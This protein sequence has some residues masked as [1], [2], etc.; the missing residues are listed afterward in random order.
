MNIRF[1]GTGASGGVPVIGCTCNVCTS[2]NIK[3]HRTRPSILISEPLENQNIN[4]LVDIAPEFREQILK[5][6][7]AEHIDALIITHAHNDHIAGLDDI[8][9]INRV[10]KKTIETFADSITVKGVQNRWNYLFEGDKNYVG[11]L[12]NLNLHKIK[13]YKP[14]VVANRFEITAI[15]VKHG[16]INSTVL[17]F[18]NL[19]N[20]KTFGY[21][22]DCNEIDERG[23]REL[24]NLDLLILGCLKDS[25][26]LSHFSLDKAINFVERINAKRTY[27][28][29]CSHHLEYQTTNTKIRQR[30]AH[31][32]QLAFDG[33]EIVV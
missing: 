9:Y 24:Q 30:T 22:V 10:S 29:H 20:K 16:Y 18:K 27:L 14:F 4:I 28:T 2:T 6:K 19:Q 1:L 12:A 3:N 32:I 17:K 8:R 13:H 31:N 11:F 7:F 23:E 26:A 15:P 21:I 33:L 5:A 25:D